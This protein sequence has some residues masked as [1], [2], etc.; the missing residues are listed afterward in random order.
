MVS[1]FGSVAIWIKKNNKTK[2]NYSGIE[3]LAPI[4]GLNVETMTKELFF[5]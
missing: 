1:V 5:Y 2:E 4:A 3:S